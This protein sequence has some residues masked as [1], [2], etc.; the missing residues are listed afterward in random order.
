MNF[1]HTQILTTEVVRAFEATVGRKAGRAR[2]GRSV[3]GLLKAAATRGQIKVIG[4]WG[5][6]SGSGTTYEMTEQQADEI[7]AKAIA[8]AASL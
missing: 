6:V 4:S 8:K 7:R 1:S 5:R 3:S 2:A